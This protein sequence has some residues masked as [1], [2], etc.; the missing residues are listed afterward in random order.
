MSQI[1]LIE[2]GKLIS[3]KDTGAEI[4]NKINELLQNNPE[5]IINLQDVISMATF[6]A[7]QI[8]GELFITLGQDDFLKKIKILNANNDLKIIINMGI[9]SAIEDSK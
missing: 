6:C 8:F 5:V 4:Y 1:D 9:S 2:Y 7:K 3:D